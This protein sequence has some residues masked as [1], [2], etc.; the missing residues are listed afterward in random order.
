MQEEV[1]E[2]EAARLRFNIS[3]VTA[4][5]ACSYPWF[6][7]RTAPSGP[8]HTGML[9][10][11]GSETEWEMN[12]AQWYSEICIFASNILIFIGVLSFSLHLCC[13][14]SL[15]LFLSVSHPPALSFLP[16][17][18]KHW[19]SH[20]YKQARVATWGRFVCSGTD[21]VIQSFFSTFFPGQLNG[22][23]RVPEVSW[24]NVSAKSIWIKRY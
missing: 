8:G 10:H 21:T 19:E 9:V 16:M 15:S 14:I 22:T 20:Q 7:Q 4:T 1:C 12:Q 2:E 11:Y 13:L 6:A 23:L 3:Q 17:G 5:V 24:G 18:R